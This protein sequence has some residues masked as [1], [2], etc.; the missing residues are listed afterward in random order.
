MWHKQILFG[1]HVI[2]KRGEGQYT[3]D[4]EWYGYP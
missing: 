2:S 1:S 4:A 3:T